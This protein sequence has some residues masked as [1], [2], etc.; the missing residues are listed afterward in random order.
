[1]FLAR[2]YTYVRRTDGLHLAIARYMQ[3]VRLSVC[4]SVCHTS[5]PRLNGSRHQNTFA[6]YDRAIFLVSWD[7]VR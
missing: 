1:M 4:L 5:E 3:P 2:V 7:P 6:R